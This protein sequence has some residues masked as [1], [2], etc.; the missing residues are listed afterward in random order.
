M[1]GLWLKVWLFLKTQWL[2]A[3]LTFALALGALFIFK[4]TGIA[5]GMGIASLTM[6]FVVLATVTA[7]QGNHGISFL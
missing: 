1:K 4:Q 2:A 5:V 6:T 3:V 7:D